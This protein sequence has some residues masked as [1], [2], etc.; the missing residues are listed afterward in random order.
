MA[1]N[2]EQIVGK[3]MRAYLLRSKVSVQTA[4]KVVI[5]FPAA[6][7]RHDCR[8]AARRV[9]PEEHQDG[10]QKVRHHPRVAAEDVRSRNPQYARLHE[11][12]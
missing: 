6:A 8:P 10:D 9:A 4:H 12:C 3:L 2:I 11:Q 5:S 7:E 1:L